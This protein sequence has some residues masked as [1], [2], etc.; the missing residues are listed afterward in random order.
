MMSTLNKGEGRYLAEWL[1]G[2]AAQIQKNLD[3][4]QAVVNEL[5]VVAE[6]LDVQKGGKGST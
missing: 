6:K 2:M 1:R 3:D 5:R 4:G